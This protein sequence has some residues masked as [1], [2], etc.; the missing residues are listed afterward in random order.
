MEQQL[1][2][3]SVIISAF[4]DHQ[5]TVRHVEE[6]MKSTRV[7]D[8]IIVVNDHGTPDLKE[9]L[10][11]IPKNTKLI[12]AYIIDDI[13]WNYTGSRNLAIWLSRGDF[14][15]LEDNDH[16][17]ARDYYAHGLEAL[18]LNPN[19]GR[20]KTHKRFVIPRDEILNKPMEEWV[21][22]ASR[23]A[24]TDCA[25]TRREVFI[26]IKGYDERFAG[27]YGWSATFWRRRLIWAKIEN[28]ECGYMYVAESPKTRGLSYRNF[29]I[30]R[31]HDNQIQTNH[32][33]LNF[34]YEF[35]EL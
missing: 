26:K 30:A 4:N 2:T 6:C 24:H 7:P 22:V 14:I 1:S 5:M 9:M 33:I 34:T 27:E 8:E 23:P 13:K 31:T 17:P 20:A 16:I 10:K 35:C 25:I 29:K 21:Q 3:L 28:V 11:A 15:S 12:Y 18:A 32:G 19:V